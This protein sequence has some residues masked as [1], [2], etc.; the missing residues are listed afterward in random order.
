MGELPVTDSAA[1]RTKLWSNN[2]HHLVSDTRFMAEADLA[3]FVASLV[4]ATESA[5]RPSTLDL[6]AEADGHAGSSSTGA[7][8][9]KILVAEVL[10]RAELS[11]AS[12]QCRSSASVAWFEM[13]LV[14]ISLRNRDRFG[15][16]WPILSEHYARTLRERPVPVSYVTE[17]Y[18]SRS[19]L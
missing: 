16:V 18:V 12:P 10:R 14:E 15:A 19:V 1:R 6:V 7:S 9:R 11:A 4:Q 8:C 13:L 2:I 17:R 5:C 3:V